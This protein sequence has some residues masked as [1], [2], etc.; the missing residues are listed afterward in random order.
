MLA[1]AQ[2]N[3]GLS[4]E[5]A[6][7]EQIPLAET[8]LEYA[9]PQSLLLEHVLK[10]YID[11]FSDVESEALLIANVIKQA[12]ED[13]M[14]KPY[15]SKKSKEAIFHSPVPDA[16]DGYLFMSSDRLDIYA[17]LINQDPHVLRY[18]WKK[19]Y[20]EWRRASGR[21]VAENIFKHVDRLIEVVEPNCTVYLDALAFKRSIQCQ[22]WGSMLL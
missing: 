11:S 19:Q 5:T 22:Y 7:P 17:Q 16:Y 14:I 3:Y 9:P 8:T 15:F 20:L 21:A 4:L 13:S 18:L 1:L 10:S 12:S 6:L 2:V